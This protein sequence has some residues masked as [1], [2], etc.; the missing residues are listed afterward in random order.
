MAKK[1]KS[2]T[3]PRSKVEISEEKKKPTRYIMHRASGEMIGRL[4]KGDTLR[5]M[6]KRGE[7]KHR[8]KKISASKAKT[9]RKAGR[10]RVL[11]MKEDAKG[12]KEGQNIGRL[13]D[14]YPNQKNT[15]LV[16]GHTRKTKGK[17]GKIKSI[18]V[19]PYRRKK[20]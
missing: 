17:Y 9:A 18:R 8:G 3:L 16:R 13:K 14:E 2:I 10:T 12:Y 1:G 11:R 6:A 5:K 4:E 15:V 7:L 20:S 19:R